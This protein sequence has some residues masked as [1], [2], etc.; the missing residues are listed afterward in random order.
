MKGK[1]ALGLALLAGVCWAGDYPF[2]PAEMTNVVVTAGFWLPRF[3]TNRL[4]TVWTD[5]RRSEETGRIA[6]FIAAG[7]RDWGAFK[8]IP[9]DDSDVFKIIEGAAYTLSTHPD[10]K[11]E[12]YL[13]DLIAHIARAQEPDG[14]LYTA[15]T[16]GFTAGRKD[17]RTDFG[18]MGPTR[19]SRCSSSHEL[20]NVGHMYEAAVAHYQATGKRTLLDVAVR[21]ADLVDRVFGPGPTQLASVPGHEE[22]ELALCKLYRVTGEARYLKLARHFL[23]RRGAGAGAR[24]AGNE[25]AMAGAYS[26]NHLP[27]VRQRE[28]VGHAVRAGYLY[29]GMADVAAL[30][31][32][33]AYAA[34][35]SAIW[36]NVV[37]KKLHLNG[38]IGARPQGEAFGANYELPNDGAYLET[39]AAIANALWN[40]R[41]FL[42]QGDAKYV[43]V[44]ERV[45]YNGF[46]SGV[47]LGGDEFFYPNPQASKGGYGRSRWFGCSCCPVNVVR[48]IPQIAQFAYATRGDAAY[49][50][51]FV[52]TAAR[53]N[54]AGGD[55]EIVQTTDYPWAGAVRLAVAPSGGARR[56]ALHVRIPGWCVGRPVPSDLYAQTEPGRLEDFALRVNGES[57]AVRP[58]K[59]YCVIDRVWRPGDTVDVTMNMPVRRIRA[60][61]AVAADRGRLAVECGPV[62]YCAEG[63]D[64]AGRVRDKIVSAD[65]PFARTTVDVLGNVYPAFTVPAR[66]AVCG[67]R[68]VATVPCT[69]KLI[70]Y[71][72]WC[73]RGAGELQTFFPTS[74][75]S[76]GA[77]ARFVATASHCHAGDAVRAMC[78]GV[79]PRELAD[80]KIPRMTFWPH[81]G[82][83]EWVA[84][85]LPEAEDVRGVDVYWFDDTGAGECRLPARW[86]VQAKASDAA[87]WRDV[88]ADLPAAK[89]AYD[90]VS[91]APVRAKFVRLAVTLRP[92][93]SGGVLEWKLR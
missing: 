81:R 82:T 1:R 41:M 37:G 66:T 75:A 44:L 32:D 39:C 11:L 76:V 74:V 10:P 85:E 45:L 30:T 51:L 43:D 73:H 28:A 72:A 8:G 59:G 78:D 40:Q 57:V 19:W 63:A 61:A 49:V 84:Y 92:T 69:L 23:D 50:N 47:S 38:G 34:A 52:A 86:K 21:S 80:R 79:E 12:A 88:T 20:Y 33:G 64:N 71:F 91:F 89:D 13:D 70:P 27:V 24:D 62:L 5:F 46:L 17:G 15:R 58:A 68:A 77:D 48:F 26:Q 2:R 54:L 53:L 22:I 55:V 36:E 60:H 7:A 42:L 56:F 9:F 67:I 93:F 16:L 65:A 25:M 31:G 90:S 14:Y 18:M 6:N 3:E 83:E 4:V 87:P 29:C 35:I